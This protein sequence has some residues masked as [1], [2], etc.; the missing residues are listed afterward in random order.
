MTATSPP[1]MSPLYHP[2]CEQDLHANATCCGFQSV[3]R[4]IGVLSGLGI[5]AS[6]AA[7]TCAM[8]KVFMLFPA[9]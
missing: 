7:C 1:L 3:Y 2:C 6:A 5:L 9:L 8:L 4:N